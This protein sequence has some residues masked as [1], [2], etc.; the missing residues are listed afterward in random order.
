MHTKFY[1][2][3]LLLFLVNGCNKENSPLPN[4]VKLSGDGVEI[5]LPAEY[6]KID[7]NNISKETEKIKDTYP[8][9]ISI[10]KRISRNP[11]KVSLWAINFETGDN[12]FVYPN[13]NGDDV[14]VYQSQ[15]ENAFD[16]TKAIILSN[17]GLFTGAKGFNSG[18]TNQRK[19]WNMYGLSEKNQFIKTEAIF[20]QS[21]ELLQ[22]MP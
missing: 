3:L 5:W 20:Q 21:R 14:D 19:A 1:I 11:A 2:I 4:W 16:I 18:V 8:E 15:E 7:M 13:T 22:T 9:V 10:Y 17:G 12:I 6:K